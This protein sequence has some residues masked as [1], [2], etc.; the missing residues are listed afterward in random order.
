MCREFIMALQAENEA[1]D[2]SHRRC[3]GK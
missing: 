3:G 1:E 2:R